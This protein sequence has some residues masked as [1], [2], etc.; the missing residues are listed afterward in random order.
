MPTMHTIEGLAPPPG[1]AHVATLGEGERFVV[2]AG[3]VPLDEDGVL[4]GAGDL[5]AQTHAV[6]GNLAA[7]LEGAGSG[8]RSVVKTS[9]YVVAARREDLSTVWDV[10]RASELSAGPHASTL[11]GVSFL[12]YTGQLVEIEAIA[13][14]SPAPAHGLD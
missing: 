5:V 8:L 6:L 14:T 2:T 10:V 4:V 1:Y 11:L 13:V 9:V 12:G 3:A 7:M